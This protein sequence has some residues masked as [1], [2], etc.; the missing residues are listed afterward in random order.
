MGKDSFI[1]Q[2]EESLTRY[3]LICYMGKDL[4]GGIAMQLEVKRKHDSIPMWG[5]IYKEE[6]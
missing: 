4:W 5:R 1:F 2:S 6:L 3:D